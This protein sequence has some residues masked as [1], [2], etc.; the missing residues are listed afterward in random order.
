MNIPRRIKLLSAAGALSLTSLI[1]LIAAAPAHANTIAPHRPTSTS[2]Y[3]YTW[4]LP[5]VSVSPMA[6][7]SQG[8]F[9]GYSAQFVGH[10]L[11]Y[12]EIW[13]NTNYGWQQLVVDSNNPDNAVLSVNRWTGVILS[14]PPVSWENPSGGFTYGNGQY[15]A[16]LTDGSSYTYG[17]TSF[18]CS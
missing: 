10:S 17:A 12:V 1:G 5:A 15:E 3:T 4:W 18:T 8:T 9:S 2:S 6:G 16:W 11:V 13:E 14:S 7:C